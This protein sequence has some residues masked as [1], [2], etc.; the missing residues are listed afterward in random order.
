MA[1]EQTDVEGVDEDELL[2]E[3]DRAAEARPD[4][5]EHFE[6]VS[7]YLAGRKWSELEVVEHAGYLLF[8]DEILRRKKDGKFEKVPVRVRVPRAHEMRAAR[9]SA[10]RLFKERENLDPRE[11]KDLFDKFENIV[12]MSQA[13]RNVSEPF[14][15][16]V[17]DPL[18]L[19]KSYD[20]MS[21]KQVWEK[22]DAYN[23]LLNPQPDLFTRPQFVALV[24]AIAE[25]RTI[26]PLDVISSDARASFVITMAAL[27]H[28]FLRS[29][30]F[31]DSSA[32]ST[33]ADS[34]TPNSSPSA[35]SE[36]EAS[37]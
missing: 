7:A 36:K 3:L 37:T 9:A 5:G 20:L 23:A 35:D 25:G 32:I 22:L 15:P 17:P 4:L 29:K 13:I 19:E 1:T 24:A 26:V 14:E 21:L 2:A 8:A 18:V 31:S 33:P 34:P 11:D 10:R 28:S 30:S 6:A 27:L 16:M 12:I